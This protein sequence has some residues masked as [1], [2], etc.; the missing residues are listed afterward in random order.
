[1]FYEN[2]KTSYTRK[3]QKNAGQKKGRIIKSM[4]I[5]QETIYPPKRLRFEY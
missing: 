4:T 3:F 1:M 5:R 2:K